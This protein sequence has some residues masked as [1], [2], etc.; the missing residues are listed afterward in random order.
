MVLPWHL[1]HRMFELA[2]NCCYSLFSTCTD[3]W[4]QFKQLSWCSS[5]SI[6]PVASARVCFRRETVQSCHLYAVGLVFVRIEIFILR[7]FI[8]L[9]AFVIF[10]LIYLPRLKY[11]IFRYLNT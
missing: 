2:E 9:V 3:F 5:N 11:E 6:C 7:Q 4:H 8:F 1:L 10:T